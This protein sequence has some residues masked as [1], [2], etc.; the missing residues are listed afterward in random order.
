MPLN[1]LLGLAVALKT[2]LVHSA[3]NL[4]D[5]APLPLARFQD[6]VLLVLNTASS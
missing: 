5:N 6:K 1:L 4:D 2:P 3:R